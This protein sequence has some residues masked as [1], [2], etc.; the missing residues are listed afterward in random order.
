MKARGFLFVLFFFPFKQAEQ[1]I[2][3]M[4]GLDSR[5]ERMKEKEKGEEEEEKKGVGR[6]VGALDI[7][8]EREEGGNVHG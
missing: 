5:W 1:W 6:Q 8:L 2:E 4:R 7:E 3:W